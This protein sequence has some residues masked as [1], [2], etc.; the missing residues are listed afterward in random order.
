MSLRPLLGRGHQSARIAEQPTRVGKD[1]FSQVA[2]YYDELMAAVPYRQW[3]DY[4]ERLLSRWYA[5]PQRVLDLCCGTGAVGW[6]MAQRGYQVIGADLSEAM[7]RGCYR[8]RP[9]LPAAVMDAS[10]LALAAEQFDLIVCLYDSL[11]YITE[12]S[13]LQAAFAEMR[14]VLR[15][16]GLA[17]FDMNT[18][19]AL[20]IGL[21]T[22]SNAGTAE[23]LQYRWV[24]TWDERRKLCRVQMDYVWLGEGGPLS[25]QETHYERAYEIDEVREM[26]QRAGLRPLAVYHAYTFRQPHRFSDRVYY[27]ALRERER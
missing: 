4:V 21:F 2:A 23:P 19:H 13:A 18:A 7:V 5:R 9:P 17:I 27:L 3:V 10:Q 26:L 20:R 15:P 12:T 16:G 14:R 11:N 6:E 25:F 22:Q 1:A 8:R 24:S